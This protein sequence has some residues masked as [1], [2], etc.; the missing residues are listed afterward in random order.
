MSDSASTFEPNSDHA[1]AGHQHIHSTFPK[2]AHGGHMKGSA[3]T[4][5]SQ[6]HMT[7]GVAGWKE[8]GNHASEMSKDSPRVSV[9]SGGGQV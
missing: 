2:M 6:T 3:H 1:H 4:G 7:G 8:P 9:Y 5:G